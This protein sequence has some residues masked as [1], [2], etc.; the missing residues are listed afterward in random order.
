MSWEDQGRQYHQWFGHGTAP[1]QAKDTASGSP[2]FNTSTG[3]SVLALAYG[4]VA[5]LPAAQ[6]ARAEAQ[7]QGQNLSGFR[8]A[9]EA[10]MR[11]NRMNQAAFADRFFGRSADDPVVLALRK[12]TDLANVATSP[13]DM[14]QAS[15][16]LADAMT[17][18]GSMVSIH[19]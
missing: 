10:W 7:F 14:A 16:N 3:D 1:K 8:Q 11:G 18:V 6:R 13:A 2:S 12:A 5:A 4:A 15:D 17:R 19:R 9:V